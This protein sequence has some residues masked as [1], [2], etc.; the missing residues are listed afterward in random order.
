MTTQKTPHCRVKT[1]KK[2]VSTKR[3][4]EIEKINKSI[5]MHDGT[6][7][8]KKWY[9]VDASGVPL[10]RLASRI[11]VLLMGKHRPY[12]TP[13]VDVGDFVVVINA[14]EVLLTGKKLSDKLYYR[15]SGYP[16]GI[17]TLTASQF[18]E[19]NPEKMIKL[20]VRRML[21]KNRLAHRMLKKLK[22]YSGSE[23]RHSAQKP[24]LIELVK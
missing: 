5:T 17:K 16:A 2:T 15:H 1:D 24:E 11:A 20:A 4:G 13:H 12:Y 8:E 22:V 18:R 10:G 3:K 9:L 21:P 7:V 23:H 19:K 6:P 14:S